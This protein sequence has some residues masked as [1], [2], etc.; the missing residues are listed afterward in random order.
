MRVQL[1]LP[2]PDEQI[3]RYEAMDEILEVAAQNPSEEFSNRQ[4]QDITGFKG[5]SVSKALSLL[6][7]LDLLVRRDVG[8]KTLY[9]IDETRLD[10]SD[11]PLLE[12]PQAEFRAPLEAFVDRVTEAVSTVVGI[13]C[14]GSVARGEADRTS[15]IDVLVLV[16]AEDELVR[17]RRTVSDVKTDLED[18]RFDG[19][20]YE[21]EPF[22]E[23]PGSARSRGERLRPIFREG[24]VL[25]ATDPLHDVKRDVFVSDDG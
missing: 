12:I 24:V 16:D 15:D 6:V 5:P 10:G 1:H 9:R 19:Q 25:Y 3:F 8:R 7:D 14:F 21:F 11:D 22:V 23:S 4:F 20:R 13:V 18:Q 17:A 2:L